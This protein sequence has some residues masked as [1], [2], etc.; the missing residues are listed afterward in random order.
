MNKHLIY[1][2]A[3][4]NLLLLT[5]C[6]PGPASYQGEVPLISGQPSQPQGEGSAVCAQD[7]A[8]FEENLWQPV[9]LPSCTSC[10]RDGDL[11]AGT[12]LV[13]DVTSSAE[14]FN[15]LFQYSQ[16]PQQAEYLLNKPSG[17][18][19]HGG[20]QNF[21]QGSQSYIAMQSWLQQLDSFAQCDEVL[22]Q[23]NKVFWQGV[24]Q[25]DNQ[26]TLRKAA[27]LF[28]GR[29]PNQQELAAVANGEATTL[30][31]SIRSLMSG[32]SFEAFIHEGANDRLL[33]NKWMSNQTPSLDLL[34]EGGRFPH[35]W[36]RLGP[37]EA[38][39][40]A[41]NPGAEREAAQQA[42]G[43]AF[44][45]TQNAV[46][47]S[48]LKLFSRVAMEE[49][50]YSEVLTADYIMVNPYSNDVYN[51][52][53]NFVDPNDADD[54][55]PAQITDAGYANGAIPHAGVL[56]DVMWLARYPS[57]DTNRNRARAR[58][59]Y[60]FFLGVDI[61]GSA[62]R[63]ADADALM[64]TNNPTLNNPNCTV[65]HIVMDPVAGAFQN[66]GDGGHFRDSWNGLDSLPQTYKQDGLYQPG[67]LW[68]RDMLAPG[69]GQQ[70]ITSQDQDHSLQWLAQNMVSDSR[71]ATGAVNFW[72]P[73]V[74]GEAPLLLP[75]EVSD[76]DYAEKLAAYTAQQN[77]IAEL[78][79]KFRDGSAGTAANGA[80][81]LKDLLVEL[82][83]SPAFR[84]NGI[85]ADSIS[86]ARDIELGT[87]GTGRLSTPEQLNRKLEA[88]TGKSWSHPWDENNDQLLRDFYG[89]YG[90]IDSD[91]VAV[92]TPDLNT[93]M[94]SVSA[95]MAQEMPCRIVI[96]EFE[97]AQGERLLF[98]AVEQSDTPQNAEQ[99]IRNQIELL[100]ERIWADKTLTDVA[101]ENQHAYNLFNAVWSERVASAPSPWLYHNDA[102]DDDDEFCRL[103]WDN[104]Q[105]LRSDDHHTI[106]SWMALLTYLFSDFAVLYE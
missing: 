72:W 79:N 75:T 70:T 57:T 36:D 16:V 43:N 4:A 27:L 78:A 22:E 6:E 88:L 47:L 29:L 100:I 83:L 12:A 45:E 66:F 67:D 92:R 99:K 41:A 103:D 60:Y 73:A 63:P 20:G 28:A 90:G 42:F 34:F 8:W 14:S 50:P 48:P 106:R 76:L 21:D 62:V 81:N 85:A 1:L 64:D 17:Q 56:S 39:V 84:A 68:Y 19:I 65:C 82:V 25:L 52:G 61:E 46:A 23:N 35:V 18:E 91:T 80:L 87:M 53:L 89:L 54:W 49:R 71:F 11:A 101:N 9:L 104:T 38:V 69:F 93:L 86:Q 5:G 59:A 44:L 97:K 37:L 77:I 94:A 105:A 95:R 51:T 74:M 33:T 7:L 32:D 40:Q 2:L 30:A 31:S 3:C 26:Q 15:R 13:F 96:D 24:E 98:T 10:H 102:N 55:Q 58:W